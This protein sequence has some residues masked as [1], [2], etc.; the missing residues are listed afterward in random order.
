MF[1]LAI[2]LQGIFAKN[3]R[4]LHEFV[5]PCVPKNNLDDLGVTVS[6]NEPYWMC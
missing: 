2:R 5:E 3:A 6:Y 1:V 4:Y